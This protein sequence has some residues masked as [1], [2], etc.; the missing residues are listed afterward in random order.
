MTSL[1]SNNYT[2]L[3]HDYSLLL[4]I[5]HGV[6]FTCPVIGWKTINHGSLSAHLPYH[7]MCTLTFLFYQRCN[8]ESWLLKKQATASSEV[9]TLRTWGPRILLLQAFESVRTSHE[10]Y[11]ELV[12]KRKILYFVLVR[13]LIQ[14]WISPNQDDLS[15]SARTFISGLQ[16]GW[17]A[18]THSLR[19]ETA[20]RTDVPL[21]VPA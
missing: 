9:Q 21:V 8:M 2:S 3:R 17:A 11:I 16:N 5:I 19:R 15:Y 10:N 20:T 12:E 7:H 1:D 6:T 18:K 4:E 13:Y 14:H